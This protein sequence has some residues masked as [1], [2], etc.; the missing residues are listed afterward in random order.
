MPDRGGACAA[1]RAVPAGR[2]PDA[3]ARRGGGGPGLLLSIA[4][5]LA[6]AGFAIAAALLPQ[7]AFA[8]AQLLQSD[9]AAG[10]LLGAVPPAVTLVFT[11]PVTPVGA[12]IKVFSPSGR[13]VAA[14]ARAG[15]SA[16]SASLDSSE[17]GT[18]VVSWQVLASDTHPSRGAFQFVVGHASPNPFSV[19]LDAAQA[20]TTTPLGLA[21]QALARFVH[22][23]GF[24]LVFGVI[25]Y[26]LLAGQPERPP[27]LV[28]AGVLLL[29]AA[30]PL[31][32]IGQLASLTFDG[33]TAIAVLSSNF[34][35][36]IGL[37]LGAALLAWTLLETRRPWPVLAIGAAIAVIDGASAHAIPGLPEIGQ[38]LVAVHV[39]ALGLWVGGLV[40]FLFAPDRRFARYAALTF[41]VAA[42]SGLILA[43]AHTRFGASLFTTDYGRVL[44]IKAVVV[45]AA[46]AVAVHRRHRIELAMVSLAVALG[47]LVV[48]LPPP[49]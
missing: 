43:F 19:L 36:V 9:P 33:D 45:G 46:L 48:A 32:L 21:L 6:V 11:E 13:Q 23:A 10:A 47:A 4:R 35:R 31:A 18:Y 3:R 7:V 38:L 25:G 20:G 26:Q 39:M 40:A 12:G 41:S 29:I 16:L 22:F 34:G 14:P 5:R 44:L 15:G 2:R 27:R 28:G 24:A 8:H 49:V 17:P 1:H 42:A 30:E 37:R